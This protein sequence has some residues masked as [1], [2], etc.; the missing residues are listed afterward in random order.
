MNGPPSNEERDALIA[1][2]RLDSLEPDEAADL[3]L[4]S[5]L[6]ADPLTWAEP[7]AAL[8]ARV[9]R[10]VEHADAAVE[11]PARAANAERPEP[12]S[13]GR[14]FLLPAVSAAAAVGLVVG[15]IFAASSSTNTDFTARL[16][17]TAAA[18]SARA[19]A[20]FTRNKAGFRVVLDA[21]GLPTLPAGEYYQA[22]LKNS[23]GTLVPIGTFSSSDG[24][25]TLWSG[26]SPRDFHAISVTIE[27]TDGDQSS[28]GH[29]VLVGE[30]VAG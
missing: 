16:S 18:P 24:R 7:D 6:L 19:S 14:R 13:R 8:E 23:A 4:L 3:A 12:R 26:V 9:V 11:Q 21:R 30:V 2:D 5:G 27:A 15:T 20:D 25:V 10:A 28:S 29:R 22:W 1:G 17:A